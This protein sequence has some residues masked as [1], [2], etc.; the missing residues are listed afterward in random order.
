MTKWKKSCIDRVSEL[1]SRVRPWV[2]DRR[3]ALFARKQW[4]RE[5]LVAQMPPT[6][7]TP[8]S[9]PAVPD[10]TPTPDP[11]PTP[12]SAPAPSHVLAPPPAPSHPLAP[13]F[14]A[15]PAESLI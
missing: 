6:A 2:E 1:Q 7:K 3:D 13:A 5:L 9:K 8:T 12:A 10:P 15:A 4:L 14:V 11:A